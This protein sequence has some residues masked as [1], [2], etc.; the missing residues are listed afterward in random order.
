MGER[1]DEQVRFDCG[2]ERLEQHI[3]GH[4][5]FGGDGGADAA[6]VG[7]V[8]VFGLGVVLCVVLIGLFGHGCSLPFMRRA[9]PAAVCGCGRCA[10]GKTPADL[11]VLLRKQRM[12][13]A[14]RTRK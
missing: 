13:Y 11:A 8:A 2:A 10:H 9:E 3:G 1:F 7:I 6:G 5:A 14:D 12:S 4:L